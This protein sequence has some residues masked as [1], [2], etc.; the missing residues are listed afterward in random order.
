MRAPH[1]RSGQLRLP[2]AHPREVAE[3]RVDLAVVRQQAHG[4]GEAPLG[5]RVGAEA[6]VQHG[7]GAHER[8]VLQVRI[9]L[10]QHRG[11]DHALVDDGARRQRADVEVVEP[12][13]DGLAEERLADGPA[14][15][16]QG[17]LELVAGQQ[18][19]TGRRPAPR[20][21]G[22]R[23]RSAG[24]ASGR[25]GTGRQPTTTRPSSR[26]ALATSSRAR[27]RL[28]GSRGRKT[29]PTAVENGRGS[30]TRC[31]ASHGSSTRQ[32]IAVSTPAPSEASPSAPTPPRCSIAA[33]APRASSTTSRS[34]SPDTRATSPTPQAAWSSPAASR[35]ATRAA[36][37]MRRGGR[38]AVDRRTEVFASDCTN[39]PSDG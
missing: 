3:Q 12:P 16:E 26:S 33:S 31:S 6:A 19:A 15:Q 35:V 24:S 13:D 5:R 10:G 29:M 18:R 4:L 25:S 21:G 23:A 7:E 2:G 22:A 11:G 32:G 1:S 14:G 27:L 36:R 8:G 9:E 28:P 37:S 20:A 34:G 39:G 17:A 38:R 30:A